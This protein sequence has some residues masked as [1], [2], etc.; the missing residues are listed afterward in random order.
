MTKACDVKASHAFLRME[1][2]DPKG[3]I[4]HFYHMKIPQFRVK[5]EQILTDGVIFM[6]SIGQQVLYGSHGVCRI[7]AVERMSFG[8]KKSNFYVLEPDSQPGTKFYVPMDNAAAVSKMRPLMTRQELLS[9]LHSEEVRQYPWISDENHRN[10]RFRELITSG[11]RMHLM[12]MICAIHRHKKAQCALGRR[13]HQADENF[14]KDA[15]NLLH[16]EFALVFDQDPR[17]VTSFILRELE[18]TH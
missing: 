1:F 11:D 9:L 10:L 15:Q 4:I 12:G 16:A 17:E 8:G 7:S 18:N 14:L 13:L 5:I 2:T 6:Y 3:K